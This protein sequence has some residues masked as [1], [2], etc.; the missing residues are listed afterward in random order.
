M[1][2]EPLPLLPVLDVIDDTGLDRRG[3][4]ALGS[5]PMADGRSCSTGHG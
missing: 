1:R 4:A 5:T 2:F 3:S